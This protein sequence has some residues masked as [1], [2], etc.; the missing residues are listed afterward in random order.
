MIYDLVVV[1]AGAGGCY[2]A[3]RLSEFYPGAKICILESAKKPLSKVEISGGGRCNVTHACYD[4]VK[5]STYY[6]RGEKSLVEVFKKFQ[7]RDVVQWFSERNIRLKTEADGRIFP[8]TD[9]SATIIDCFLS[10]LKKRDIELL[11]STRVKEWKYDT[12]KKVWD[13]ELMD[14]RLLKSKYLL[15]STGSD[16]RA[17]NELRAAG[18]NLISPV[19][20]LFTFNIPDKEL[21]ALMGISKEYVR[22]SIPSINQ[23]AE[24]P[25][26]ITHWGLSGPA[27]L[28][29]SA[30]GA[31]EL[32]SCGYVFDLT[33][34]WLGTDNMNGFAEK[35]NRTIKNNPKK[36]IH[37]MS[38][39]D[40]PSRLWKYLC[41]RAEIGEFTSGAEFGK[42]QMKRLEDVLLRD[43]YR[44]TGKSTFKDEFVT[45]GG[46]DLSEID[47]DRFESK[48]HPGLFMVG[49]ILNIDAITGGFNF[50]AA[51][52]GAH[53]AAKAIAQNLGN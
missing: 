4:P 1:G 17:W 49:E 37:S 32:Y 27:I 39:K 45:A 20:S 11:T 15:L 46:V 50:Q 21:Q 31:R 28:K 22:L 42:K 13:V 52:T 23:K 25:L 30:W 8:V 9:T 2:A 44:V 26:L 6:P 5:L 40:F 35:L 16:Q 48:R 29:L 24:G 47:M 3:I 53:M 14:N 36:Y 12:E 18:Y 51:W 38:V 7:P 10:E 34:N 41:V 19:P 43:T 33:V